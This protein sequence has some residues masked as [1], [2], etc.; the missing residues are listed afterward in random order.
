M[1][2]GIPLLMV[3]GLGFIGITYVRGKIKERERVVEK[4][5]LLPKSRY[6]RY[7]S[8]GFRE[9]VADL[10]WLRVTQ[11]YGEIDF[12]E[13]ATKKEW[14]YLYRMTSMVTDLD[15]YF[16]IPY[17]FSA[18]VFPWHANM[19]EEANRLLMKGMVYRSWDW[20]LPFYIGFNVYYFLG[21]NR[22]A[23][24]YI[25]RASRLPQSPQYL[26][27]L[28]SRLLYESGRLESAIALLE[29][30]LK[31]TED[32]SFKEEIERRL[33]AL[34]DILYLK[35]AVKVYSAK[36]GRLPVSLEDL[37]RAG[38]IDSIP[39]EPYGGHYYLDEIGDVK[40]TTQL[41]EK[42]EVYEF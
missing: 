9:M 11:M 7:I 4:E 25:L 5:L 34:R 8:L 3:V 21:D 28:A 37:V 40:S 42:G 1:R 22:K 38:I 35:R 2:R 32:P 36:F 30:I 33:K 13:K 10:L 18:V 19:V 24:H 27:K 14:K 20:R 23:A 6:L 39:V 17:Y 12:Q 29:E 15:P 26:P 16:F 31:T 41:R